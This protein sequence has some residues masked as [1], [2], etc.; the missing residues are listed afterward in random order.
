MDPK[1]LLGI[2]AVVGIGIAI[3]WFKSSQRQE[4]EKD[5][6]SCHQHLVD[7]LHKAPFYAAN[8]KFIKPHEQRAHSVAYDAAYDPG[9]RRRSPKFDEALYVQAFCQELARAAERLEKR[10]LNQS[11]RQFQID[12]ENKI[13]AGKRW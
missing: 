9:G 1:K 6:E 2:L 3:L 5:A 7:V 4:V 12:L 10:E 11:L 13:K 8:E